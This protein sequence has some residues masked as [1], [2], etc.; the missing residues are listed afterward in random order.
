MLELIGT[1]Y[2]YFAYVALVGIGLYA[3]IESSNLVKKLIGLNIFQV[4]IFLFFITG[5]YITGGV[6]PRVAEGGGPYV[7]PLPQVA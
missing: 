7:S 6:P 4:G 2:S 3:V 1:H 5:G